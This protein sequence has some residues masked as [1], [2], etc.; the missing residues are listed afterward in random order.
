MNRRQFLKSGV[1]VAAPIPVED[2]AVDVGVN[3]PTEAEIK[4]AAQYG[5]DLV[6]SSL[7]EAVKMARGGRV[8]LI[9]D[10]R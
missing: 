1:V 10:G 5:V 4:N 8:K 7:K 3:M 6:E 9:F 2:A